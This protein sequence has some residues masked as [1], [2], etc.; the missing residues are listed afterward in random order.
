VERLT[1]NLARQLRAMGHDP[2]VL[3][4]A[5]HSSGRSDPYAHEGTW[6]VPVRAGTPS[7]TAP[8][9]ARNEELGSIL[10]REEIELVHVM[11]PLRLPDAFEAAARHELPVIAHVADYFYPC[12][13]VTMIRVDGSRCAN[14]ELGHA[15]VT[16]CRIPGGKERFGW[17]RHVLN[18]AS[19]VV[20]PSRYAI[21]LHEQ[22]GF[23]VAHWHHVP[24]GVDYA[25]HPMRLPAPGRKPIVV[26]FLGTLLHHKGPHVLIE[27]LRLAP[28]AP[29]ELRLYGGSFHERDY[30]RSL[31]RLAADDD[32]ISFRGSYDHAELRGILAELDVV[33]IPSL[34][35]ENLPTVGLNAAAA[36]VPLLGSNVG[37]VRE[38][39]DDYRCGLTFDP[40]AA[41]ELAS[42]LA[43]VVE[44]PSRLADIRSAMAFPPGVEEEAWRVASLYELSL[45]GRRA[46][47]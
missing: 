21:E 29:I 46:T 15:C 20:S 9:A 22:L 12:A 47:R 1:L 4:S 17:G 34:W 28:A 6:V 38:L 7:A 35:H 41:H 33:A 25:L 10:A 26:G 23:D 39:I 40:G 5:E 16:K 18:R 2:I 43:D 11:Q 31:R 36:G 30:E 8:W 37:G 24:W 14:A 32:R 45:D 3:T 19:A 27:A 44:S 13:R 42:L